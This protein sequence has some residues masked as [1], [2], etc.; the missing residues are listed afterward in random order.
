MG[1]ILEQ[2]ESRGNC[3]YSTCQSSGLVCFVSL[4]GD[5]QDTVTQPVAI[6][7]GDGHGRLVIIRHGDEAEA[8]AFVGVEVTDHLDIID[9]AKRPEELP[10]NALVRIW[11]QVVHKDAPTGACVPR[12]VHSNQAGHAVNGDG[13]KPERRGRVEGNMEEEQRERGRE[14]RTF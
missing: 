9:S 13:R 5:L 1:A 4:E 14:E 11:G 8:F 7:T 12:D 2:T 10:E 6:E 3:F